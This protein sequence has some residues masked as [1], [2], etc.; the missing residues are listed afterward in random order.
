MLHSKK[1]A[2]SLHTTSPL[3]MTNMK[4]KTK[5]DKRI[6]PSSYMWTFE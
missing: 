5:I 4:R 3:L 1:V 2:I 6:R